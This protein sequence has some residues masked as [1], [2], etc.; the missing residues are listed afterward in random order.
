MLFVKWQRNKTMD[1]FVFTILFWLVFS[2]ISFAQNITN[3]IAFGD[4]KSKELMYTAETIDQI[5]DQNGI[6][7]YGAPTA[8]GDIIEHKN[9]NAI[10]FDQESGFTVTTNSTNNILKVSLGSAWTW[11]F[12]DFEKIYTN[13]L[14]GTTYTNSALRPSGEESIYIKVVETNETGTFWGPNTNKNEKTFYIGLGEVPF[15]R[16]YV[17]SDIVVTNIPNAIGRYKNGDTITNGTHLDKIFNSMFSGYV[18]PTY[19]KPVWAIIPSISGIGSTTVFEYGTIFSNSIYSASIKTNDAGNPIKYVYYINNESFATNETS[20]ISNS[21]VIDTFTNINSTMSF[22][23]ECYYE[24]GKIK[25]DSDGNPYPNGHISAGNLSSTKTIY[26]SRYYF[27]GTKTNPIN[28]NSRE[29]VI[30]NSSSSNFIRNMS[31][32][33]TIK[34]PIGTKQ[35]FFTFPINTININEIRFITKSTDEDIT[36]QFTINYIENFYCL[37]GYTGNEDNKQTYI[38]YNWE[39]VNPTTSDVD[40]VF[41]F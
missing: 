27:S 40:I 28:I 1:K 25:P 17:T 31:S 3:A 36:D 33:Y 29:L 15:E 16:V 32:S 10:E 2:V 41:K 11:L 30:N 6:S 24:E 5:L 21:Q 13:T 23:V 39:N 18:T 26:T 9:A 12:P 4:I 7:I 20:D 22:K 19:D 14:D 8:D 34:L 37:N 38:I 35:V